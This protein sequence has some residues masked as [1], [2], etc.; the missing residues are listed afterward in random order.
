MIHSLYMLLTC[1]GSFVSDLSSDFCANVF[2]RQRSM[3]KQPVML[4]FKSIDDTP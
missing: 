4:I 2:R 3:L 1:L